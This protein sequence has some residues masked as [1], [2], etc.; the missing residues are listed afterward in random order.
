MHS[1]ASCYAMKNLLM[2]ANNS[3][4][5]GY[6]II[7]AAGNQAGSGAL[8]LNPVRDAMR[9]PLETKTITI[10]CGKLT[11]WVTVRPLSG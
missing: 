11:T 1:V 4:Y 5:H 6:Q 9:N 8:A 7:V 3:F 2:R 10:T